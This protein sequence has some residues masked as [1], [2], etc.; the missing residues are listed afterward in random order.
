VRRHEPD[1]FARRY[2]LGFLPEPREMPQIARDK[3]VGAG[4]I[5]TSPEPI[6]I[7]I[8]R[9]F[10]TPRRYEQVTSV[11]DELE[12]LLPSS[13]RILIWV[14]EYIRRHSPRQQARGEAK[15]S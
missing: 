14:G 1:K 2:D 3:V 9:H 15:G 13:L 4:S 12:Q 7:G 5:G 6:V 11:L 8:A 10:K